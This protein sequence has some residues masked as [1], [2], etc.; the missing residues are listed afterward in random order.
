[1]SSLPSLHSLLKPNLLLLVL[2][3]TCK[4]FDAF[5]EYDLQPI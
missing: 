5:L 2:C 1:M 3:F 4:D